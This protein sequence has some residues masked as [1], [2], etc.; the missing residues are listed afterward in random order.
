[1]PILGG[2]LR[3]QRAVLSLAGQDLTQTG[4]TVTAGTSGG[5]GGGGGRS[6][7]G[8]VTGDFRQYAN[9]NTRLILGTATTRTQVLALRALTP[10]QVSAVLGMQGAIVCFRDT[11]GRKVFGAFLSTTTSDIPLS[12]RKSAGTLLSDIGLSIQSVTWDEEV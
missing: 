3:L 2:T 8:S 12:G 1:M 6:D 9:G 10:S 4:A 7:L 5:I 11:Y